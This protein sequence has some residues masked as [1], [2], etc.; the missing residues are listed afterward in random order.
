[1][2]YR[3]SHTEIREND[4]V[5]Y[6]KKLYYC[7]PIGSAVYL[8]ENFHDIKSK[9][10]KL[11]PIRRVQKY[12]LNEPSDDMLENDMLEETLCEYMTTYLEI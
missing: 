12:I 5:L 9:K 6:K 2:E 7:Y 11:V 3:I 10:G 8:F 1:M 4:I